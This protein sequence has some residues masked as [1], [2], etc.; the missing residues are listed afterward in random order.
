MSGDRVRCVPSPSRRRRTLCCTGTV[1]HCC[2]ASF[3]SEQGLVTKPVVK[4]GVTYRVWRFFI[5]LSPCTFSVFF[6][7]LKSKPN[8]MV[9]RQSGLSSEEGSRVRVVVLHEKH[10]PYLT[11]SDAKLI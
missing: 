4:H 2:S 10:E 5:S 11:A 7:F 9:S 6:F 8:P 3:Q 1:E